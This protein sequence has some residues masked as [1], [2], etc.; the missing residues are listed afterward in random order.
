MSLTF[1]AGNL[2]PEVLALIFSQSSTKT[3][4]KA[5]SVNK[6][7]HRV[8]NQPAVWQSLIRKHCPYLMAEKN[9]KYLKDPKALYKSEFN[10]IKYKEWR[11][12]NAA[13]LG[14]IDMVQSLL[15]QPGPQC[16]ADN[17]GL[18]LY[19]AAF[20]GDHNLIQALLTLPGQQISAAHKYDALY[21]AATSWFLP[22]LKA[23]HVIRVLLTQISVKDTG[24]ALM[25]SIR[26][27]SSVEV[28]QELL[29]G[30]DVSYVIEAL[31]Q[32][33]EHH[34]QERVNAILSQRGHELTHAQLVEALG[35]D[36]ARNYQA[37]KRTITEILSIENAEGSNNP[38]VEDAQPARKRPRNR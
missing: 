9:A 16:S 32:A 10:D 15:S 6:H 24:K 2:L 30:V 5:E 4:L 27:S 13:Y 20:A 19:R 25:A 21:H 18:M 35:T 12:S 37:S 22:P 11:L 17:K 26:S 23:I 14:D 29:K 8:A 28:V 1:P 7:W 38:D 33:V 3:V 36:G 31:K 34:R